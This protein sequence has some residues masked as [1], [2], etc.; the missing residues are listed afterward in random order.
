MTNSQEEAVDG[1]IDQF[2]VGFALTLHQMSTLHTILAEEPQRVV[3]K[4][5]LN[6]LTFHH[7]LLHHL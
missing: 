4:E 5:H 3:F 2:L 6:V 7:A 1:N